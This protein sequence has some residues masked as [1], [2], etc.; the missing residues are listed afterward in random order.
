MS[1]SVSIKMKNRMIAHARE[2]LETRN[3][4][5]WDICKIAIELC[6]IQKGGR[7]PKGAYTI[8]KFAEDIGMN[9]KTLSCWILDYEFASEAV[10]LNDKLSYKENKRLC[11]AISKA[12]MAVTGGYFDPK[13]SDVEAVKLKINEYL[14][15]SDSLWKIRNFS[16]NLRHHNSFFTEE[17]KF[18]PEE[19]KFFKEYKKELRALLKAVEARTKK[20][21][22]K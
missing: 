8:T 1:N 15:E 11:G 5:K 12:R 14:K 19:N 9:R 7:P 17:P 21:E 4:A 2:L 18:T 3:N 20:P 6:Y 22:V 16:K 10:D 13:G